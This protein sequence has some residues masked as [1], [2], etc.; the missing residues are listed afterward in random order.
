MRPERRRIG[1]KLRKGVAMEE[2]N[3]RR[4][5]EREREKRIWGCIMTKLGCC[6]YI[7][8]HTLNPTPFTPLKT[9]LILTPLTLRST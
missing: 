3:I 8:K 2:K 9:K 1:T 6:V 7:H 5:R 4:G